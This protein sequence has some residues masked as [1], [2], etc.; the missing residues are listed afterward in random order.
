MW[1]DSAA[2]CWR[3]RDQIRRGYKTTQSPF[4][5]EVIERLQALRHRGRIRGSPAE[6]RLAIRRAKPRR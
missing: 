6:P 2:F 5:H 1:H 3:M 4:A